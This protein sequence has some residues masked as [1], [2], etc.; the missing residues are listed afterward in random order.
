[1]FH[2]HLE[3]GGK[4]SVRLCGEPH[5]SKRQLT[6]GGLLGITA[7]AVLSISGATILAHSNASD[8]QPGP[9]TWY[10]VKQDAGEKHAAVENLKQTGRAFAKVASEVSPAVVYIRVEK[11]AAP[12][13]NWRG[14]N[15]HLDIARFAV[16]VVVDWVIA[17]VVEQVRHHG[18]HGNAIDFL[19]FSGL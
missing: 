19:Q 12:V 10:T 3:T 8:D 17:S 6:H 2:R 18:W 4:E 15:N 14:W 9:K 13:V 7:V 1:M 11:K 5:R 16:D